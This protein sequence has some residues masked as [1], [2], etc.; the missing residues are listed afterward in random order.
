MFSLDLRQPWEWPRITLVKMASSLSRL[1]ALPAIFCPFCL[2]MIGVFAF[3]CFGSYWVLKYLLAAQNWKY[4]RARAMRNDTVLASGKWRW[5]VE[6]GELVA[7]K[8]RESGQEEAWQSAGD[9]MDIGWLWF[10]VR[11]EFDFSCWSTV[12][13]IAAIHRRCLHTSAGTT[14]VNSHSWRTSHAPH[15][16]KQ[17]FARSTASPSSCLLA[18]TT[19]KRHCIVD[20]SGVCGVYLHSTKSCSLVV[21]A[22]QTHPIAWQVTSFLQQEKSRR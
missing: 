21:W 13:K 10:D 20:H 2:L 9:V 15:P 1:N 7:T 3:G 6:E 11:F 12:A 19:G 16:W 18:F 5:K 17:R 22:S 4:F 14:S 8:K